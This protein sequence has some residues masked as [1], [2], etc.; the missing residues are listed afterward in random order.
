MAVSYVAVALLGAVPLAVVIGAVCRV[1]VGIVAMVFTWLIG[2]LAFDGSV[3]DLLAGFP[4]PLFLTLFSVTY[5]FGLART[6]GTIDRVTRPLAAALSR[7]RMSLPP[8][9]FAMAAVLSAVGVGNIGAV[10][11][12]AP[13]GMTAAGRPGGNPFL[14]AILIVMGANAGALS[15]MAFSGIVSNGL[16]ARIGL[17][18][19]PWREIFLPSLVLQTLIASAFYLVFGRARGESEAG[20]GVPGAPRET[21][22]RRHWGTLAALAALPIGSSL[23]GLDIGF[24]ALAL[25]SLLI[26]GGAAEPDAALR[27]VP[28]GAILMV[29]GMSMLISSAERVGGMNLLAAGVAR[30]AGPRSAAGVLAFFAGLASVYS[31]SSGVVMPALIPMVPGLIARMDGG[32]PA[33]LVTA[34]NVGSH[35]VDVSPL[36]TLGALCVANAAR[37]KDGLFRQ[38]F[39]CGLALTAVGA[40]VCHLTLDPR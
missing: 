6:N 36:S 12:L 13:L 34:I 16:A 28:W 18:M 22:S 19:N 39:V 4:T 37:D 24:S 30:F 9:F 29:C 35:I 27:T 11:L 14:M 21:W 8:A 7:G 31:S 23:F 1:N 20:W 17:T 15:P 26:I 25:A 3:R 32:D 33:A 10:A 40:A 5:F 2:G 38:L